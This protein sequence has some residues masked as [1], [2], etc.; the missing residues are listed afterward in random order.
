M[1]ASLLVVWSLA[2]VP[3]CNEVCLG[4]EQVRLAD[5]APKG[6]TRRARGYEDAA[7][8]YRKAVNLTPITAEKVRALEKMATVYDAKHLNRPEQ[9]DPI[10]RELIALQPNDLDPIFR[11]ARLQEDRGFIEDA[12]QTLLGARHQRPDELEPS[13]RLAQFYLRLGSA[14]HS[15]VQ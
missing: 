10:L 2:A 15:G 14:L 11:L 8:H 7:Q 4:D 3:Q 6:S 5:A 1:L 12:E 9:V 13:T